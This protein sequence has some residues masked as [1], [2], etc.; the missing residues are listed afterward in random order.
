MSELMP[1][2]FNNLSK[3]DN[4]KHVSLIVRLDDNI[5]LGGSEYQKIDNCWFKVVSFKGWER[6]L[7]ILVKISFFLFQSIAN[8]NP[9]QNCS[10]KIKTG[11]DQGIKNCPCSL[12]GIPGATKIASPTTTKTTIKTTKTTTTPPPTTP[13]PTTTKTTTTPPPTTTT[14]KTTTTPPPPPPTTTTTTKPNTTTLPCNV[15]LI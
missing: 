6:F 10:I 9:F 14:T 11:T 8:F 2:V 13:P 5:W 12:Y 3:I 1:R 7:F 4:L 15:Y